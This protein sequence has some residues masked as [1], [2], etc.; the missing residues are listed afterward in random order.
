MEVVEFE[1]NR[2]V[3][4]IIHDGP[5]EMHARFTYEATSNGQTTLTASVEFPGMDDSMD[6]DMLASAMQQSLRNIKRLIE[7]ET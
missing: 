3:G 6:T 4:M 5:V 7:T 2:A 1:A